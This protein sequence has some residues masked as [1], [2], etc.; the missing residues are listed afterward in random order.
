VLYCI[1]LHCVVFIVL[2]C[3]LCVVLHCIALHCVLLCCVVLYC[4]CDV[5]V[6][7]VIVCDLETSKMGRSMSKLG[8]C[9]ISYIPQGN[10]R[11]YLVYCGFKLNTY[12]GKNTMFSM[13]EVLNVISGKAER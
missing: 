5:T 12:F 6:I 10:L 9:A 4:N 3:V 13:C 1:A 7:N 2:C 11:Q 8:C